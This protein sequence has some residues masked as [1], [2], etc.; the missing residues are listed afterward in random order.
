[1]QTLKLACRMLG[2]DLRA[3]ELNLLVLALAI[4]VAS[5]TSVGFLTDRVAQALKREANQLLGGDPALDH[6]QTA[7]LPIAVLLECTRQVE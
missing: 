5:L 3:G 7:H 2:R 1:M 6:E 4:A